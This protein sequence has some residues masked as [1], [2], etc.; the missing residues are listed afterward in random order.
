M[1]ALVVLT[2]IFAA[3][4][5]LALG[6]Q[7]A[8]PPQEEAE[9]TPVR[10]LQAFVVITTTVTQVVTVTRLAGLHQQTP[11]VAIA[12]GVNAVA[13]GLFY[14]RRERPAP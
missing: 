7:R 12:L 9:P 8:L 1:M 10:G 5:V 2:V 3:I 13:L 11:L 14:G 6:L 4:T